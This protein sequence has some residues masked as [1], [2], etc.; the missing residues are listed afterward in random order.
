M[1]TVRENLTFKT[2]QKKRKWSDRI[3]HIV[4][5]RENI[6]YHPIGEG[7]NNWRP[8]TIIYAFYEEI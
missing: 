1:G 7:L 2:H 3:E 8:R 4:L 6:A 5:R